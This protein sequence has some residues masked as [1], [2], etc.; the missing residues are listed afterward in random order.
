MSSY[1]G[2]VIYQYMLS[3]AVKC[4]EIMFYCIELPSRVSYFVLVAL[5]SDDD[6]NH[7]CSYA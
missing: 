3:V 6:V 2:S 7:V 5:F 1:N 4:L